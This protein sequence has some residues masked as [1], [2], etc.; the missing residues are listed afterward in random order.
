MKKVSI[1]IPCFNQVEYIDDAIKSALNQTYKNIEIVVIND[2][3][4]QPSI[5]EA[6]TIID[7]YKLLGVKIIHTSNEGVVHARNYAI[8]ESSGDYIL[9]L[10]ADDKIAFK[11]VEE[12]VKIFEN[13]DNLGIVY[14]EAEL[15]G[16]INEKWDLP[17]YSFPEILLRNV[18]FSSAMFR[19][20]DWVETGGYNP[21]MALGWEDYDFWLSIIQKGKAVYRIPEVLFFYRQKPFSRQKSIKSENM[22]FLFTNI[23][24][25]HLDLYVN[26][27]E[28]LFKAYI[29]LARRI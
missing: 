12:C 20:A 3:S 17:I 26:N 5:K 10:D 14:C 9:P 2:G 6:I 4:T 8:R 28:F 23:F 29:D 11:Y 1:I 27:I 21:N 19:K 25:N 22:P 15:F 13:S 24:R 7:S 18:I 16:D